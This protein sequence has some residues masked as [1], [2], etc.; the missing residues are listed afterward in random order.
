MVID[1]KFYRPAEVEYLRGSS[2]KAKRVLNWE[3]DINFNTL[4]S[5]MVRNDLNGL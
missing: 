2:A 5:G 4:V 3:P 1:P